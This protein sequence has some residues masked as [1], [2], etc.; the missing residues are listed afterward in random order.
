LYLINAITAAIGVII[1]PN[2]LIV[3]DNVLQTANN[4]LNNDFLFRFGILNSFVCQIVFIFLALTLYKLFENV[5]KYLSKT[6][7]VLVVASV[8]IVFYIIFNQ[9]EALSILHSSFMTSYEQENLYELSLHKFQNYQ[10]GIILIG[11]FWGLWLIPFGQL[12]FKSGFIPKIFGI[13]LIAGGISYLIDVTTFILVP[14]FQKQT[15]ILVAITS[16]I[17]ELSMILWFLIKG[18]RSVEE[19]IIE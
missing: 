14:E 18:T 6:L 13:L 5:S 19:K 4:V 16:S 2:K 8:P 3:P 1:I 17:A 11:I 9:L 10:N 12:A 15:N 7:F